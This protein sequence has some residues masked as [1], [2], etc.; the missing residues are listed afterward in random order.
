MHR[1]GTSMV[2]SVL[3]AGGVDFGD[4]RDLVAPA[5]DNPL[6][7]VEHR[8]VT[9]LNTRL[10]AALDGAWDLPPG[11]LV[12]G[13]PGWVEADHLGGLRHDTDRLLDAMARADHWGFKDPRTS[14]VLP[15][16]RA[17]LQDH[18]VV[19]CVRNPLEVAASLSERNGMSTHL[20]LH[21]WDAYHR[22][23]DRALPS[24]H[25]IVVHYAAVLTRPDEELDRLGAALGLEG[26]DRE[27]A[28]AAAD[29]GGRH[30]RFGLAELQ[31]VGVPEAVIG[32]Y[33]DLCAE[34]GWDE[35]PT[36][37]G[38]VPPVR[39]PAGS[40]LDPD[41]VARVTAASE[42]HV[43]GGHISIL[44]R[45][46]G[47]LEAELSQRPVV[48]EPDG[49]ATDA[50][51][52]P[53][54]R[55]GRALVVQHRL[56]EWDRE[57]GSV[58]VLEV[59]DAL[60]DAGWHVDFWALDLLPEVLDADPDQQRYAERLRSRG[61]AVHTGDGRT[62][63]ELIDSGTLDLCVAAFWHVGHRVLP[64]IR[65]R[66]PRTRIVVD[67][68]D[69][70]LLRES[71]RLLDQPGPGGLGSLSPEDGAAMAGELNVYAGADAVLTVSRREADL[72]DEFVGRPG[73]ARAVPLGDAID[74]SPLTEPAQRRGIAFVGNFRH[75][76]NI[77]AVGHLVAGV[78]PR[79]DPGLLEQHP[80]RVVGN[81]LDERVEAVGTFPHVELVGWVP[82]VADE[83]HAARVSVVPLLHGAGVKG[84][85]IQ[86]LLAG[87][88][89][90]STSVGVE[91]LD[92][93]DAGVPPV[94]VAD[95]D[96]E[97][98]RQLARLLTD[99][100][101]WR[102]QRDAGL[103][104]A[105]THHGAE[106][107]SAAVLDAL[108]L[109]R[110]GSPGAAP[111]DN[112]TSRRWLTRYE[113]TRHSVTESVAHLPAGARV[114]VASG[115]DQDL[116]DACTT[117]TV[118]ATH[119]P[120]DDVG[121]HLGFNPD[122]AELVRRLH[123][124]HDDGWRYLVVPSTRY[125]WFHCHPELASA[126]AEASPVHEDDDCRV[127][128]LGE[129]ALL[130][131]VHPM[132]QDREAAEARLRELIREVDTDVAHLA[133][134]FDDISPDDPVF[135]RSKLDAAASP[136]LVRQLGVRRRTMVGLGAGPAVVARGPEA[137]A[138]L[139]SALLGDPTAL[140]WF[141]T[142]VDDE[143][144]VR[145][146]GRTAASP[147]SG[148]ARL[149]GLVDAQGRA[150]SHPDHGVGM[151]HPR[152]SVV[153]ATR[154]RSGLLDGCLSALAEQVSRHG[155][156]EV[157]VVDDGSLDDTPDVI[158][159]WAGRMPLRATRLPGC[160]R[161]AAKNLGILIAR[162]DLVLLL[163]DD[164][165]LEDGA[166]EAYLAARADATAEELP[167][168]SI[169]GHTDWAPEL[170][171]TPL[172]RHVTEVGCQLFAYPTLEAGV[173]LDWRHFW[174]GRLLVP[175]S[176][177][178]IE[179]LHDQRLPYTIDVELGRRLDRRAPITVRYA[180][181]A[182]GVMARGVTL[183]ALVERARAK[184]RAQ[185]AI[186][187][188]HPVDDELRRYC[189]VA[190]VE[191]P[192]D[193]LDG[194][195]ERARQA[196]HALAERPGDGDAA[197]SLD[198]AYLAALRAATRAGLREAAGVHPVVATTREV[199]LTP[200]PGAAPTAPDLPAPPRLSVIIPVW[201]LTEELAR[202]AERT[203]RRVR[204]VASL[205]TEVIVIDNG[206]PHPAELDADRV[207]AL[208]ENRGVGP[209]WNLGA[210]VAAA[211]LLCFLNSD[212]TVR[213]GW[214]RALT[215]AATDGR[216]IAFPYTDHGDGLGPRRPDQAGTA[217]WCFVI[218]RDLFAEIGGFDEGFAPAYFEDTD[219]WHR[220]WDMG[221]DLNP[222][223]AAVVHH[224]RRTTGRLAEGFD[225][226]FVAHRR[227]YETKHHLGHDAVPPFH[228]REVVDYPPPGRHRLARLRPWASTGPDRPR[229]FGLGLAKTGTSSLHAAMAH[230]GYRAVHHGPPEM[231]R[232]I[233]DARDEGRPMLSGV[234]PELDAFCDIEDVNRGYAALDRD[235]PGSKFILTVRDVESWVT[236]RIRHVEHNRALRDDGR[237]H[238]DFLDV[239]VD[240]WLAER[241]AHHA[242]V[243]SHF[244]G[245][246]DDLLVIDLC[247]GQGWERLAPFLGWER[248]PERPFPWENRAPAPAGQT[249]EVP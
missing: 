44:Q 26:G 27:R 25:R 230:L 93:P 40:P 94:V 17:R 111:T 157:V 174:E 215:H 145:V 162:G 239:D 1:S 229:V 181:G 224:E 82:E 160:G 246:P 4:D 209:A 234:D 133:V 158:A 168:L 244:A 117:P 189:G 196:E 147:V 186:T 15:W 105:R 52:P 199:D 134:A 33:L 194:L 241:E 47:E 122:G 88:P 208:D 205:P 91:G 170:T 112:G 202:M 216:R 152:V 221:V 98:A 140:H 176:L 210:S 166:L 62:A 72:V 169:L 10:L 146:L 11:V 245:R 22:A 63:G 109:D 38:A 172:M 120:A 200:S 56:P 195:V 178:L 217:G 222:V 84:K 42:L 180:P 32:R 156:A 127:W 86:S 69:L 129:V 248:I 51:R 211:P 66:S 137:V 173:P 31:H 101:A 83:L 132:V 232:A 14:L 97:L 247:A 70:H 233:A 71:R 106:V 87:T 131:H 23:I 167:R 92:L 155:A 67:S 34:A 219:Y 45:Q 203:V 228:G 41:A 13:D 242:A 7:F 8:A 236:S 185:W 30:H 136:P 65:R 73:L 74:P 238:G 128:D 182:R 43:R 76:P 6:G 20:G 24:T 165:R 164:D 35:P 240:G 103:A 201:S 163:D 124:A 243:L 108:D 135:E 115:G 110:V 39:R 148:R 175:R 81:E 223:P 171:M 177:L 187:R 204:E 179:G 9:D 142:V 57:R 28:R 36:A 53:I 192:P 213:P 96:A 37:T 154:D 85:V 218:H 116:V 161:S 226:I 150:E 29:R 18:R 125:W 80:V 104:W 206:S 90:V 225:E 64:D 121:H 191:G 249:S 48:V 61:V 231:R 100:D 59:V 89:V 143:H 21:L 58:R 151:E 118:T 107:V 54:R 46:V 198:D 99:D 149:L 237:P 113:S 114:L 3:R 78:L 235:Y 144:P 212:C 50:D 55:T 184:G 188:L 190:Q 214:D 95:D 227:R 139:R 141:P 126:L 12:D 19:V 75:L 183:G 193:D 207:I 68:I 197:S 102:A 49:A 79:L 159:S 123:A 16:W 60:V 220:A 138:A 130:V 119:F 77:E 2:A 153:V 5:A